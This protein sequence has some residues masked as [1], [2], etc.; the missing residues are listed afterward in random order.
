LTGSPCHPI[1]VNVGLVNKNRNL[2]NML[3]WIEWLDS[4]L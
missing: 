3:I 2:N 4:N 1:P